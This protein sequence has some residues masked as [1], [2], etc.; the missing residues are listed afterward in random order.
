MIRFGA[1]ALAPLFLPIGVAAAQE[2]SCASVPQ[3]PAL[4]RSHLIEVLRPFVLRTLRP[5]RFYHYGSLSSLLPEN[6]PA[7]GQPVPLHPQRAVGGAPVDA[8]ELYFREQSAGQ[9]GGS[10]SQNGEYGYGLYTASEPLSS[11]SY[12]RAPD[13][14]LALDVPAGTPYLDLRA[15]RKNL[16]APRDT[17]LA[18]ACSLWTS[19]GEK[20]GCAGVASQELARALDPQST[21]SVYLK[22]L[23]KTQESQELLRDAHRALDIRF[24]MA[25]WGPVDYFPE[26]RQNP[27]LQ[28]FSE[29][30]FTDPSFAPQLGLTV[31]TSA[32]ESQ[33]PP[34]KI[35]AYRRVMRFY[36]AAP[37]AVVNKYD[38]PVIKPESAFGRYYLGW[39]PVL[40]GMPAEADVSA[41]QRERSQEW[42][43][44]RLERLTSEMHGCSADPAHAAEAFPP[45]G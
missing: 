11:Q 31:F 4:L 33:P 36:D 7:P 26:C 21:P 18:I 19:C 20:E 15:V 27:E 24:I 30:I 29:A 37:F 13:L 16:P 2:P 39:A 3:D 35:A 14:L 34:E 23:L 38:G 8:A 42:V 10:T 44:H 17:A 40:H 25:G 41:Y 22:A 1:W 28:F 5:L 6:P 12:S 45:R 43:D 32:L 9:F